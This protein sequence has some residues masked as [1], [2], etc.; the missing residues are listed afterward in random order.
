M[1]EKTACIIGIIFAIAIIY[2]TYTELVPVEVFTALAGA[3]V[4]WFY[5]TIA[6]ARRL[7]K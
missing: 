4:A 7:K 3:S 6:E 1:K 5:K 2:F